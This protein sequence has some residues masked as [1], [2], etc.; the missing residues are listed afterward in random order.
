MRCY[1]LRWFDDDVE[2]PRQK[3]ESDRAVLLPMTIEEDLARTTT[4]A[5]RYSVG[6]HALLVHSDAEAARPSVG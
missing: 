6:I 2:T 1:D 3:H 4:E 5:D